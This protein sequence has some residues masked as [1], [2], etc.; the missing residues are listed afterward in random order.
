MIANKG[1]IIIYIAKDTDCFSDEYNQK[2]AHD[3]DLKVFVSR[4]DECP[5]DSKFDYKFDFS[6]GLSS[7]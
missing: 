2:M 4:T 1:P 7:Y 5:N 6:S 3:L